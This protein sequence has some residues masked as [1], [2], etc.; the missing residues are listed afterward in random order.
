MLGLDWMTQELDSTVRELHPRRVP[1]LPCCAGAN[2]QAL[3]RKN[4]RRRRVRLGKKR[5]VEGVCGWGG[6]MSPTANTWSFYHSMQLTKHKHSESD[7]LYA[8]YQTRAVCISLA[9][10]RLAWLRVSLVM[11]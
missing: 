2:L 5:E 6:V 1:R 7:Y 8:S 3:L 9:W 11:S 4:R 10:S